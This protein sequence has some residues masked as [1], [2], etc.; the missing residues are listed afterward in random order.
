MQA[1]I[2]GLVARMTLEEKA[3]LCS[4][5]DF[6]HTKAVERLGI[7]AMM[8]S[9]GPHGLRKQA[10]GAATPNDSI[11]AVCFPAGCAAAAGFDRELV[12][13]EGEALG[14]ECCAEGVGLLLGPAVNLKRSPL[15][16][17]NF[18]Y[19]SEDPYLAGELA[20]AFIDGV[21]S[22]GVGSCIKHFAANDQEYRRMTVSAEMDERTLRELYLPAFETA[23]KT[24]RPRTVMCS[25]NRLR[26]VHASENPYLLDTILRQEWGFAGAVVSDWGA[27]NDRVKAI[28]AGLDLQMPGPCG[29]DD[30]RL[31]SA[32]RSGALPESALDRAVTRILNVVFAA[33]DI[34]PAPAYDR[35]AHHKKAA[36]MEK[37]CAVLLKNRGVLPL[38]AAQDVVYI[39]EFAARPRYQGG[40]SS[41]VNASFVTDALDIGGKK[42]RRVRYVQGFPAA[43]D[44]R[45]E[46][47]FVR[48]VEAAR[49]ADA[50]VIFAGLPDSFECEGYDRKHMRLPDCQNNLIARVAAVQPNTV[51]VLHCGSPVECPWAEDVAAVLCMYLGGEGVGEAADALLYGDA[52]PC[53]RLPE[54]WPLRLQDTPC[55]LEFPG[56]GR[57]AR[58]T[59]GPFVGY[60]WYDAREMPVRWPFGHGLSYTGFVYRNARLSAPELAEGGSV[61]V[62]V[63]VKNTG[64]RPGREVV[65]LYV[66]PP[67]IEGMPPRPPR[68]LKGFAKLALAP[69]EE[70][71]ARFTVDARSLSYYDE[72]LGGWYAAPGAYQMQLGHSSRD[73]HATV[74][75]KYT[76][77]R[78]R[79][80]PIDD[81]TVVG[82]LLRDDRTAPIF[83]KALRA[84]AP[85][86]GTPAG[87]AAAR[88][89]I[90]DEMNRQS[91]ENAPL[92]SL[93]GEGKL[94]QARMDL[95]AAR[96]RRAVK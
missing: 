70:A 9:D 22:R 46:A 59:E 64:A 34:A 6:W 41:H 38:G 68:E 19:Y 60:R 63:D 71:T 45:D 94:D 18:E 83:E 26:G 29:S 5:A 36:E 92:R 76:T 56:D 7:P 11:K 31:V 87:G 86:A 69:G 10:E 93:R 13:R 58:Y 78:R 55:Y 4:G 43:R 96:L 32:V 21:Q 28:R 91:L 37:E 40:G 47:E 33:A 51:V 90:T 52:E 62:S 95:L 24:A 39:G 57:T 54:S 89:A 73:I 79:P 88:E 72:S 50:A 3:G 85:E 27:V 42:G 81:N 25:Y 82:D 17:R 61:T 30:A 35:A 14:E 84:L 67:K 2:P 15:C 74:T 65:Q 75:L 12:R 16:G 80:L 20:A 66:A 49:S 8:M 1:T 48:A 77:P 23:V 44:E 53:G